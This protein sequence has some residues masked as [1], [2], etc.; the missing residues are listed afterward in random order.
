M[1]VNL[2]VEAPIRVSYH[3]AIFG[4]CWSTASGN[5]KYYICHMTRKKHLIEG[6]CDMS[7]SSSYYFTIL[8]SLVV[9]GIV[10]TELHFF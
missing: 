9:I 4:G 7:G 3:F 6:S 5:V 1:Y 8:A 2:G 10:V